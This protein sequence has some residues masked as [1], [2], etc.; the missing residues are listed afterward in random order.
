MKF[1]SL[2]Y[3]REEVEEESSKVPN[4]KKNSVD[5]LSGVLPLEGSGVVKADRSGEVGLSGVRGSVNESKDDL[6]HSLRSTSPLTDHN[7]AFLRLPPISGRQFGVPSTLLSS[8]SFSPRTSTNS[9]PSNFYPLPTVNKTTEHIVGRMRIQFAEQALIGTGSTGRVFR[10]IDKRTN[11]LIAVKEIPLEDTDFTRL[12]NHRNGNRKKG[13]KTSLTFGLTGRVAHVELGIL[14]RLKHPNIV[15]FLGEELD[16]ESGCVRIYMDLV[17]G[18]SIRSL[19]MTYGKFSESQTACF[20]KQLLEGLVYLH[21]KNIVHCDLKGDNLLVEPSGVLKL[22]DFGTAMG[23][24]ISTSAAEI[25]GT[26]F[27]MSPEVLTRESKISEKSDI[28]SVG[29][30]VVEMLNGKPPLAHLCSQYAIMMMIGESEGELLHHYLPSDSK[31]WSEGALD[32]LEC[33][34]HRKPTER[35]SAAQLLQHPWITE[36]TTSPPKRLEANN[37]RVRRKESSP[38]IREIEGSPSLSVLAEQELPPYM[39]DSLSL[40]RFVRRIKK[41][42]EKRRKRL[43][44]RKSQKEK[45]SYSSYLN[46]EMPPKTPRESNQRY[47]RNYGQPESPQ[48]KSV[49]FVEERKES[50]RRRSKNSKHY[51]TSSK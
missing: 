7:S 31:M 46:K 24:S 13:R 33:C 41:K 4:E 3:R 9:T 25:G 44:R 10:A 36:L 1:D 17:A 45:S 50:E 32:F 51:S 28:W 12:A 42:K 2:D 40:A 11:R 39:F 35:P 19:L 14:P 16:V 6:T 18:G 34:L 43:E 23:V 48:S 49:R 37:E 29:C 26:A 30:C 47:D 27:F 15:K 22:A 8:S 38:R 21:S 5:M 20:T